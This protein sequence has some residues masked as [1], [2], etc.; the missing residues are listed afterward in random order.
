[1]QA[2]AQGSLRGAGCWLSEATL[3]YGLGDIFQALTTSFHRA[4]NVPGLSLCHVPASLEATLL[5]SF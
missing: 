5:T 4:V 3:G 1:M 2:V